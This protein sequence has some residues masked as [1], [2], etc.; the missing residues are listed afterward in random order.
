MKAL[1]VTNEI[2]DLFRDLIGKSLEVNGFFREHLNERLDGAFHKQDDSRIR[3]IIAQNGS[4]FLN[5]ALE[6]LQIQF[7]R[8]FS[9]RT[10][11]N[12]PVKMGNGATSAGADVVYMQNRVAVVLHEEVMGKRFGFPELAKIVA[13]HGDDDG[14]GLRAG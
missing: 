13:G 3:R 9:F 8:Y 14:W 4:G 7:E 5:I 11:R 1:R 6:A 10:G 12:C 2:D